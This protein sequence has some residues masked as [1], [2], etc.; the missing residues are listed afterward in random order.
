MIKEVGGAKTAR[1]SVFFYEFDV[2]GVGSEFD[3][4]GVSN[5]TMLMVRRYHGPQ[6]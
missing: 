4:I 5:F 3:V 1:R 2:I 6:K